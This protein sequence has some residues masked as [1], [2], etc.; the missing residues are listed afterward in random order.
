MPQLLTACLVSSALVSRLVS[1]VSSALA[2]R[3]SR[4]VSFSVSSRQSR[5][6]SFSVQ[7]AARCSLAAQR[8]LCASACA[9]GSLWA[10][11]WR[12]ACIWSVKTIP[13]TLNPWCALVRR[14]PDMHAS[15]AHMTASCVMCPHD[16]IL[17][18]RQ[19]AHACAC[20]SMRMYTRTLDLVCMYAHTLD[21][22]TCLWVP[23]FP[24]PTPPTLCGFGAVT[25]TEPTAWVPSPSRNPRRGFCHPHGTHG[26]GSGA[27]GTHGVGSG[28]LTEPTPWVPAA[29][30]THA[31]GSGHLPEPTA[32]VKRGF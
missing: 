1:L 20:V 28:Q 10:L 18:P 6:V 8:A 26:V 22:K 24:E 5:L 23:A 27:H 12:V 2:S 25:P 16:R 14:L 13:S 9:C 7:P 3:Q 19:H 4:L 15:C 31:V 32:W 30:G 21:P 11:G 17:C 29:H